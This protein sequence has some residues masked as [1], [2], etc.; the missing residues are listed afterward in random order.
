MVARAPPVVTETVVCLSE[1]ARERQP[2]LVRRVCQT[3]ARRS[4]SG[5]Q[6]VWDRRAVPPASASASIPAG[7]RASR[8]ARWS[9]RDWRASPAPR[10]HRRCPAFSSDADYRVVDALTARL[11][12]NDDGMPGALECGVA[13]YVQGL[14]SA[15]PGADANAD[16]QVSAADLTAVALA[17][18]QRRRER[19]RRRRRR[20]R[21]ARSRNHRR[22]AVRR[23]RTG[24]ARP[25]SRAGR[26]SPA[27]RSAIA[28]RS[29]IRATGTAVE[30]VP[31]QRLRHSDAADPPAAPGVDGAPARRRRRAGGERQPARPHAGRRR[32]AQPLSRRARPGRLDQR[33]RLRRAV[34]R[35]DH[36]AAGHGGRQAQ[37]PA[38]RA[39]TTCSSTTRSR[40][41]SAHRSTAATAIG[42]GWQLVGFDGDSQPLG[43]TIYDDDARRLPR[44]PRQAELR[45]SI[46]NEPCSGFSDSDGAASSHRARAARGRPADFS[47]P[48]CFD[49]RRMSLPSDVANVLGNT[50]PRPLRR[51]DHRQRRRRLG[52]G[53][54]ADE[55]PARRC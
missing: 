37:A 11:V 19:R 18:R 1:A 27:A 55:R 46:P 17:R 14:L 42:I 32:P 50:E 52:G 16:G 9:C 34:R 12:S 53:V 38:A 33:R 6:H 43:Y 2:A 49:G 41:C 23:P 29:P 20:G 36:G 54:R 22:L 25:P 8:P 48:Y 13:D 39:S 7:R 10:R 3:R 28:T 45:R 26:S 31:R 4:S 15:F 5:R 51:A 30:P 44:A 21:R 47:E 40:A 24:R 35:A